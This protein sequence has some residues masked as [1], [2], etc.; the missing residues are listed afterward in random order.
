MRRGRT[1]GMR[2]QLNPDVLEDRYYLVKS[3]YAGWCSLPGRIHS[4]AEKQS[5]ENLLEELLGFV[6]R[7][8]KTDYFEGDEDLRERVED[9]LE[10][11]G[12]KLKVELEEKLRKSCLNRLRWRQG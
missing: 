10:K 4:E 11:T 5:C 6:W 8:E 3:L 9:W 2:K 7:D 12:K 1:K